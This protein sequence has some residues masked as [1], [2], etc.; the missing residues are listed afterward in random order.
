MSQAGGLDELERRRD[1]L[2]GELAAVG[3]LRPGKLT[4]I[5]RKCGRPSCHCARAGD[6]GHPGWALV[7][8]VEGRLLRRGVPR[9]AV[10]ETR[11][12]VAEHGR[13]KDLARRFVEASEALC[14]A[15]LKA[16]RDGGRGA[17][18]GGSAKR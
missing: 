17:Q 5:T 6:P 7:R 18:K 13:F 15:R 12:Q 11:A 1:E 3:D 9:D 10:G 2:L 16:G 14:R 4:E 8:R